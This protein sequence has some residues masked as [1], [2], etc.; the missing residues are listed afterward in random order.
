MP[1]ITSRENPHIKA[2]V[3]LRNAAAERCASGKFFLEGF[4]LCADACGSGYAP[5]ELFLTPAAREKYQTAPLERAAAQVFEIT[6]TVAQKLGDTQHP[7][8]VFAV[9][10]MKP[11]SLPGSP[12]NPQI[13]WGG[14]A[15]GVPLRYIALENL[16]DP[17]NLGAVARTAEALGLAGLIIGNGCDPWHPKAL[18]ASMGALLRLPVIRTDDLPGALRSSGLPCYAA[19]PDRG[20][21]SVLACDFTRG[22]ILA[23]GSEAEGL[24]EEAIAA[25]TCAVTVPMPGRAESLNAAAAA[26]I[27]MW[28]MVR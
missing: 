1:L 28:E 15:R 7:Q 18:R 5:E 3:R 23:V 13:R 24:S 8:G 21:A 9:C 22:G 2:A 4:R 25:C 20:A 12:T 6:E 10:G 27:L 14:L 17:G 26:T 16:Q 19:V 11:S